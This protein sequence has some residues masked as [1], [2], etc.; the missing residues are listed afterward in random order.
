MTDFCESL[1]RR[2]RVRPRDSTEVELPPLLTPLRTGRSHVVS[3]YYLASGI[4][5]AS[6]RV[7]TREVKSFQS[8][9]RTDVGQDTTQQAT[10]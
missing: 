1:A 4:H 6:R 9:M 3:A 8:A 5:R 7:T 10:P 2:A